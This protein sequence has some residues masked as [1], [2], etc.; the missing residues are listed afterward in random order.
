LSVLGAFKDGFE[1]FVEVATREED[2]ALATLADEADVGTEAHDKP[3]GA[4]AGVF[5]A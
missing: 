5:F 3:I 1:A 4:A 2:T